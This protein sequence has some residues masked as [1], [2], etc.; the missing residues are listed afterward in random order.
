MNHPV[1]TVLHIRRVT[2]FG[3]DGESQSSSA[4]ATTSTA[5]SN[6]P[7]PQPKGLKAR[8][9]PFGVPNGGTG[10]AGAAADSDGDVEMTHA[11]PL[12]T[13]SAADTKD[14][15]PKKAAKKRKH[16]DVEKGALGQEEAA[17]TPKK[18]KKAR[19][20]DS[21]TPAVDGSSAKATKQT[22]IAPP[23]I[24][25]LASTTSV[26]NQE[27]SEPA[28]PSPAPTKKSKNKDKATKKESAPAQAK[29][30][31]PKKPVKV[32]P[33]MPPAVPGVKSA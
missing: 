17:S 5:I 10:D 19:V 9:V 27:S 13:G 8:Y 26:R 16:G 4:V 7:R 25:A 32:T 18:S 31:D 24:P 33:V 2:R 12:L 15:T 23:P 20:E 1:N 30:A 6:A 28:K 14:D 22:P 3:H 11:P 29:P 21:S